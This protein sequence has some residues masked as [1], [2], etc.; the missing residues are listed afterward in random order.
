MNLISPSTPTKNVEASLIL[1][2]VDR[3]K[4]T[5]WVADRIRSAAQQNVISPSKQTF[6]EQLVLALLTSQQR[7]TPDSEV[8]SFAKREPFPLS[9]EVYEQKSDDEI[10]VILKS[11]RFGG[12]ITK[13]L[14]ANHKTLFG[15]RGIW[16][17]LSS[18]MQALAQPD[19]KGHL[20]DTINQ[21]RKV[22]HLLS[23][24][25][26]G[27]GPK[28]SRNLLQE[29][30]LARYEIPLD[31]RVA[32]WLGEN[33]GWNMPNSDLTDAEGYEFWLD[34]LQS[35]C[36]EAGVLPTVFDAAAF[37]VGK[38]MPK[39]KTATTLTGYVNKNGQVVVR[40]TRLPGTDHLQRVYQLGCSHCGQV[41]GANGSDIFQR[42]C[43]T[44]Q[45]GAEGNPLVAA[46]GGR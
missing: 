36:E 31:S 16:G 38:T 7:S 41:Y 33:L 45:G 39:R 42:K 4:T 22:A 17:E 1:E 25:L 26:C 14:R 3:T 2:V 18:V 43:P 27:I 29:L 6:W 15:D 37:E 23:E 34:R 44:C 13:F 12:P 11:F 30:G 32:G 24:N 5:A 9:L 46:S 8:A 40:N 10:R 19:V 28:Q 21:E 35:V 20:P